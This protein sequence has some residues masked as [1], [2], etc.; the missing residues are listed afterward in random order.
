MFQKKTRSQKFTV[1]ARSTP[2]RNLAHG[3]E[4]RSDRPVIGEPV[5][6]APLVPDLLQPL[7]A[8][9]NTIT[10][11]KER[12]QQRHV[13][14]ISL[15]R[16]GTCSQVGRVRPC[17]RAVLLLAAGD[18]AVGAP[19]ELVGVPVVLV[20]RREGDKALAPAV[21]LPALGELQQ[22]LVVLQQHAPL[23]RD[24]Q[25]PRVGVVHGDP[26]VEVAEQH[27]STARQST[28]EQRRRGLRQ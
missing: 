13:R 3:V 12:K 26:V 11:A 14:T 16:F 5:A 8:P 10:P 24:H 15:A 18:V 27:H 9:K 19:V 22:Q 6:A 17:R 23:P 20:G 28:P 2:F 1:P 7:P 25:L 21:K 4:R